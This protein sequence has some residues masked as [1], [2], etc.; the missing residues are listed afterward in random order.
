MLRRNG[1]TYNGRARQVQPAELHRYDYV[2]AMDADNVSDL[3][4]M[5]RSGALDGKLHQLL[6]FAP[7]GYPRDVPDPYYNGKFDAVYELVDAGVAGLLDTIR[8]EHNLP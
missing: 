7:D 4:R 2:I 8:A 5:D 1:I 3:R 6:A